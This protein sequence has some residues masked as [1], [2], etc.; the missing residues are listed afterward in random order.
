MHDG[1]MMVMVMELGAHCSRRGVEV[2]MMMIQQSIKGRVRVTF[3]SVVSKV[4]HLYFIS[5]SSNLYN[6]FL[7]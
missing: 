5:A 1:D 4:A 7:A 6:H 2:M 3:L